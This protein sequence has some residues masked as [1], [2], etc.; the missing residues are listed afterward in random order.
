MRQHDRKPSE[1]LER[2]S[3]WKTLVN[4]ATKPDLGATLGLLYGRRRQGK[5]FMLE[6]LSEATNGFMFTA[7]QRYGPANLRTLSHAYQA[8]TDTV[9]AFTDWQ[10]AVDGLLRL[11]ERDSKPTLVVLDEFP[12]LLETE[13][14]LSSFIQIALSPRS[15]AMRQSRTRLILCGSALTTMRK[16]LL[17]TAPL[18]GRA[19]MELN[20]PT[21]DYREA[22]RLWGIDTNAD[23]AF[24]VYALVGGTPAYLAMS[25][26]PVRG[27][28]DF[29]DW[30]IRGLLNPAS[31]IFREGNTLLYEQPE[32]TDATLYFSVLSAIA[33]GAG[34]RSEIAGRLGRPDN[35]LAHPLA[36]LE[37]IQLVER[38]E[39]ALHARRPIYR[40]TEPVIRF[41]ELIIRDN[42]ALIVSGHGNEVWKSVQETI[43]SKIYGP[44]FATI[45]R[46][47]ALRYAPREM[48]GGVPRGIRPAT[49]ACREH[50]GGHELDVVVLGGPGA[51]R[52]LAIGEAKASTRVLGEEHLR[53]LEHVREL[54]GVGEAK[55]LLF[56]RAGFSV[57]LRRSAAHRPDVELI[58][59]AMLYGLG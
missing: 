56:G 23:L 17:G 24:R 57:A 48:I 20:L 11:G 27:V 16:L 2:D 37:E 21:L 34:R 40:I 12:Y 13:P 52:V 30:V 1:L 15:R 53:R 28:R 36:L 5:T 9:G 4:F 32:L 47:W 31:A 43:S 51:D 35:A 41:H 7:A 26:G 58:D 29:D 33:G 42:E 8:Y 54:I 45:S 19:T 46:E 22:A 49:V 44:A 38:V 6:L 39:D 3:E 50:R 59:L 18:R 25:H 10:A 14:G 55:L